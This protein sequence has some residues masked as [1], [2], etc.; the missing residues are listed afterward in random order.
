VHDR[1]VGDAPVLSRSFGR[2]ALRGQQREIDALLPQMLFDRER[3]GAFEAGRRENAAGMTGI[4]E[5]FH[6]RAQALRHAGRRIADAVV[7]GQEEAHD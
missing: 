4:G 1:P 7:I 5:P 6:D 3:H 2:P